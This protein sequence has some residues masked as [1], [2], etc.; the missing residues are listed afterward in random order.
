MGSEL[1]VPSA[2]AAVLGGERDGDELEVRVVAVRG[3]HQHL[4]EGHAEQP[5]LHA[6]D[7][8]GRHVASTQEGATKH[9][10]N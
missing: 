4:T 3:V 7:D 2:L 10:L 5:R 9:V 6:A 8:G 1:G